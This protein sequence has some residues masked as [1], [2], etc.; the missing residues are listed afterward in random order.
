MKRYLS[1]ALLALTAGV[2][3]CGSDSTGPDD[4][5]AGSFEI[6]VTGTFN[7]TGEGPAWFGTDVTD[8]G[9]PLFILLL[10]DQNSR[11]SVMLATEGAVRPDVGTYQIGTQSA[12]ELIHIISNNDELL[13]MFIAEDGELRITTSSSGALRGEID[14]IAG[15]IFNEDDA[16]TGTITFDAVP[17]PAP[18]AMR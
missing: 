17:A 7:E 9:E 3:A 13:G 10:G 16:V 6:T 5:P 18:G 14:F 1:T 11:H 15:A 2:T 4:Q 8:S 12:W